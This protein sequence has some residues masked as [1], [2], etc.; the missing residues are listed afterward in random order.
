MRHTYQGYHLHGDECFLVLCD[1][2]DCRQLAN[3]IKGQLMLC[4]EHE[5]L[6]PGDI[7]PPTTLEDDIKAAKECGDWPEVSRLETIRQM[8]DEQ[9]D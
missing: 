4:R 9:D 5:H 3:V 6:Q 1:H 7:I 8:R 2:P